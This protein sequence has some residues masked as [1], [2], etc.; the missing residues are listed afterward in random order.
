[1]AETERC[2]RYS[3]SWNWSGNMVI[4]TRYLDCDSEVK[5]D[6]GKRRF[7]AEGILRTAWQ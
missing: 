6:D 2:I 5:F 1:M 7:A 3:L 4:G